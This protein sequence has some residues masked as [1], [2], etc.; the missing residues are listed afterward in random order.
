MKQF[1]V[2][3]LVLFPF[4]LLSFFSSIFHISA[5]R[6]T[7]S[8]SSTFFV[9]EICDNGIDDDGD[10]FIDLFD[11]DCPCHQ[12]AFQA[13]CPLQC[14][15]I[16]DTFPAIKLKLKWQSPIIVNRD[17]VYPNIVIGDLN[18]DGIIDIVTKRSMTSGNNLTNGI[19]AFNGQTGQKTVDYNSIPKN[20]SAENYF[21]SIADV[22]N[23][24]IAEFFYCRADTIVCVNFDGTLRW[25][26]DRLNEAGG[27]IVNIADFNGDGIPEVYKGNNIVNAR[28]GKLLVNSNGSGGCNYYSFGGNCSISHT[29][30]ADLL[31]SPGLELA[32]GNTV[33]EVNIT[34]TNGTTGN[35]MTAVNAN[36]PVRDGLTSVGDIDGD[37]ELD[38]VVVRSNEFTDGGGIWVWNPR[39]R[40]VIASST[41]G[42]T[43]GMAF[44]GNVYGDCRPEIGVTFSDRLKML[45]YNGTPTLKVLYNLIT[46]DGSGHTGVTMFDFNQDGFNELIYRDETFLRIM[47][48][49]TGKTLTSYRLNNG[50]GMEYPVVADVDG[51][52]EAEIIVSGWVT[53]NAE[54]RLFCFESG[55]TPWAPAR[56]VWNQPGYHVTNVNDDLTIPRYQQNQAKPLIGYETC[57]QP[58]CPAPYNA[59][60]AQATFRTQQGCV[61]FPAIDLTIK[62]IDAECQGDSVMVC[63]ALSN[64]GDHDLVQKTLG[65]TI[66]P[67]EPLHSSSSALRKISLLLDLNINE[68]DTFCVKMSSG[69]LPDSIFM[70]VNDPGNVAAPYQFP[71]TDIPECRYF[72][73]I[74]SLDL[75]IQMVLIT[76]DTALCKG[77]SFIFHD[78]LITE[79]GHYIIPGINCDSLFD[80]DVVVNNKDS[81]RFTKSICSSDSILFDGYWLHTSGDYQAH[82]INTRGCDSTTFLHLTVANQIFVFDTLT[83]CEGDSIWIINQWAKTEGSYFATIP[84]VSCDT[85]IETWLHENPTYQYEVV[86]DAC[87]GDSF[88]L[89]NHWVTQ[90][91]IVTENFQSLS[92]C[93][94]IIIS[95]IAMPAPTQAPVLMVNCD[96]AYIEATID[97][98]GDWQVEWSNGTNG[99]VTQYHT[100]GPGEVKLYG[101]LACEEKY[102]FTVPSIP[103][104]EPLQIWVDTSI[105]ENHAL[106]VHLD[107]DPNEWTVQWT[108]ASIFSC[109]TCL[110]TIIK[111]TSNTSVTANLLHS[112]GCPY[113]L[114]FSISLEKVVHL[115]IPN[116]F[117]PNGDGIN[118]E[119]IVSSP[120][121]KI[122]IVKLDVFDRWGN[123]V[124]ERTNLR[125]ASWDGRYKDQLL[126]PGV[127]AYTITYLDQ[128]N[129]TQV[130]NGNIT[131][132]R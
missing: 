81:L 31:P 104:L 60:M 103:H 113:T 49:S 67:K 61:Q 132:V 127:F 118:D 29:I 50:T 120:G 123:N 86:Y 121:N 41:A 107:L 68:T 108:P 110:T 114:S 2:L 119:W 37:G 87:P 16:P 46:T 10:G 43:G 70:A 75:N 76:L 12:N 45:T 20:V 88:F 7:T 74:D 124:F 101:G 34:N 115:Y 24:G 38:V 15:T 47:E 23:D 109:P 32:A 39:T 90:A 131:L 5:P 8:N 106:N 92:G 40:K 21:V 57:L 112:S 99:S 84:G 17:H 54:Q 69:N 35:S 80:L 122:E 13:Y 125:K 1:I 126:N 51:D 26:S 28:T 42:E 22:D 25:K 78:S 14:E 105:L 36:S 95:D 56:S 66:W 111:P 96:S 71:L 77:E 93:D 130:E 48:G 85:L 58:T 65:V 98:G 79:S 18:H 97:G 11:T 89:D 4:S 52:D 102:D 100:E 91:E 6:H 73:N 72:N 33:Y 94:S 19:E 9:P 117:S 62:I 63:Y 116:V 59:F 53:N 3:Y 129:K 128:E 30:A 82:H 27:Y 44:I 55:G 64:E 83:S